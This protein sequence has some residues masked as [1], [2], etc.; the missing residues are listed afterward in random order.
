VTSIF[1][2]RWGDYDTHD[3]ERYAWC[4]FFDYTTDSMSIYPSPT[5]CV[6][7][8]DL[9]YNLHSTFGYWFPGCEVLI[10]QAMSNEQ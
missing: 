6:V 5:G 3:I 4:K 8:V 2:Y 7:A 10:N 1:S 9:A